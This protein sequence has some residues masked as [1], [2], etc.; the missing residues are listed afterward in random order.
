[1]RGISSWHSPTED[2]R[3]IARGARR[4]EELVCIFIMARAEGLAW[5][6][7]WKGKRRLQGFGMSK[8]CRRHDEVFWA[9]EGALL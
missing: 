6:G 9:K 8:G 4:I 1:L 2:G 3:N 7:Y 5:C